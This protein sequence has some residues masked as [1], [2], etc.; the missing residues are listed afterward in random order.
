[1]IFQLDL[2]RFIQIY[3]AQFVFGCFFLC[4]GI[5][6]SKKGLKGSRLILFLF[7]MGIFFGIII[8]M[9]YAPLTDE[10][11]VWSLNAVANFLFLFSVVFLTI[12]CYVKLKDE[13]VNKPIIGALSISYLILIL[14]CILLIPNNVTINK[15]TNWKPV[16][17]NEF[18][19][20]T[21]LILLFYGPIPTFYF[22]IKLLKKYEEY[23][24]IRYRW[25]KILIGIFITYLFFYG[26]ITANWLNVQVFRTLWVIP[27]A[28]FAVSGGW[29]I[30]RGATK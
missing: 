21:S 27:G 16:W 13:Q 24:D 6:T 1:M 22:G 29:L 28:F 15:S 4:L 8:N 30:Y 25:L 3:V 2:T 26:T 18:F 17:S 20:L 7:V 11:L 10:R 5:K 23:P 19:I 14:L 12:F 9:I